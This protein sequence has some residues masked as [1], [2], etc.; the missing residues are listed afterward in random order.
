MV[1]MKASLYLQIRDVN[2]WRRT[3]EDYQRLFM[4]CEKMDNVF[5][6]LILCSFVSNIYALLL[7]IQIALK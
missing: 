1:C 6:Y 4:F 5:G 3:R 7:H 2:I